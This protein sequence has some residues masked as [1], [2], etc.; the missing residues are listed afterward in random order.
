MSD[1]KSQPFIVAALVGIAFPCNERA[2][3]NDGSDDAGGAVASPPQ[4]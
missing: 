3:T 1:I 2:S 4:S